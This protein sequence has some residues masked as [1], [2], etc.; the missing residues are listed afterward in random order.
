MDTTGLRLSPSRGPLRSSGSAV[1]Q[2]LNQK[3]CPCRNLLIHGEILRR[4]LCLSARAIDRE[5]DC[6]IE[7]A[8]ALP[9]E[10]ST[11]WS[12]QQSDCVIDQLFGGAKRG[13]CEQG[14]TFAIS[15]GDRLDRLGKKFKEESRILNYF[16]KRS[17]RSPLF[18]CPKYGF[19]PPEK[20]RLGRRNPSTDHPKPAT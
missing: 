9:R 4:T 10:R 14:E 2:S 17:R 11:S 18:W 8:I 1:L 15:R 3:I 5:V 6:A 16:S 19:D 7:P 12:A 13:T 20:F